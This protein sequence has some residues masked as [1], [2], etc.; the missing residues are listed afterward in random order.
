[1]MNKK[2]LAA[3]VAATF[4]FNANAIDLDLTTEAGVKVAS[5]AT[6]TV[7]LDLF[8]LANDTNTLDF[9]VKTGFVI[10]L[11]TVKYMRFDLTNAK[12]GGAATL[13]VVGGSNDAG[14]NQTDDGVLVQGGADGDDYAIFEIYADVSIAATV[15]ATLVA[16]TYDVSA[17]SSSSIKYGLYNEVLDAINESPNTTFKSADAPFTAIAS[18]SSGKVTATAAAGV[19]SVTATSASAFKKFDVEG[20]TTATVAN[21]GSVDAALI[22]TAGTGALAADGQAVTA[23]DLIPAT[24]QIIT[25]AGDFSYGTWTANTNTDCTTGGSVV[26]TTLNTGKTQLVSAAVNPHVPVFLCQLVDGTEVIAKNSYSATLATT[27]QSGT[28]GSVVYD[29]TSIAVPYLTTYTDYNQR[30]YLLNSSAVDANYTMSFTSEAG[31]T[32]TAGTAATGTVPAKSMI[33]VKAADMVTLAGK[34]RTSAVIEVETADA[35]ISATTQTVNL[36]DGSTDTIVL[37]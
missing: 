22:L 26:T 31:V 5:E 30:I 32:A 25:F 21:L 28:T 16:S 19:G 27:L 20:N 17:T 9:D 4:A 23:L 29:T 18:V 37:N 11:D 8:A 36:S 10:A 3:A 35:N 14:A 33:A 1:M 24:A 7:T 13:D 12:F 2:I 34:T 6:G 15:V